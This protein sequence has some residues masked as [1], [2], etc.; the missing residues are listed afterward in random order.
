MFTVAVLLS[1][2]VL[3]VVPGE[4]LPDRVDLVEINHCYNRDTG[5]RRFVQIIYWDRQNSECLHVRHWHMADK[6]Q[7]IYPPGE[8]RDAGYAVIRK[9]EGPAGMQTVR[10]AR[11]R[12][13][14]TF[15]DPEEEDRKTFP[16]EARRVMAK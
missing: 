15:A 5:D 16:L 8:N 6:L 14:H 12:V 11:Y 9:V 3:G 7:A 2:A 4:A 1:S 10:A 13:T